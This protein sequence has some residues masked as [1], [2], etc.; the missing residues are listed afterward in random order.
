MMSA[1][2]STRSLTLVR[3]IKAPPQAV[4]AAFVEPARILK[5]WGPDAGPTLLAETEVR[6]GGRFRVVFETLDGERHENGGEYLEID[7]PGRLVMAWWWASTPDRRSR[8]T[9]SIRPISNGSE[10]TVHHEMLFDEAARDSH[11]Q[12]WNGALDKL[13]RLV[14]ERNAIQPQPT[15]REPTP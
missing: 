12:G 6:V 8:V 2:R 7:P 3:R 9:V 15:Q 10:L 4:F 13:E 14:T 1:L 11:L 5:W